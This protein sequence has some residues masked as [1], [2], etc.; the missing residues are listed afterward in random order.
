ML[1][2]CAISNSLIFVNH[3]LEMSTKLRNHAAN[4][5]KLIKRIDRPK[6]TPIQFQPKVGMRVSFIL[7]I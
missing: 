6:R 1:Q 7:C 3:V 4:K 5:K 2:I